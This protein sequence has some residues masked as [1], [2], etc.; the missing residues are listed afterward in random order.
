[1]S[2]NQRTSV[3]RYLKLKDELTEVFGDDLDKWK[4]QYEHIC[5]MRD[6]LRL[7]FKVIKDKIKELE[8][9]KI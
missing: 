5:Q 6:T 7:P 8:N 3:T 1:M 2:Y 9:K 4:C